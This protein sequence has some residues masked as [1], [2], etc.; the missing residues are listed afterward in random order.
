MQSRHNAIEVIPSLDICDGVAAV[1]QHYS[2]A[3]NAIRGIRIN[4]T[5]AIRNAADN[6]HAIGDAVAQDAH[7]R[8]SCRAL[9]AA[10]VSRTCPVE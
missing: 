1:F 7:R 9:G 4:H 6:G 8:I 2:D 5:T 10:I 3:R